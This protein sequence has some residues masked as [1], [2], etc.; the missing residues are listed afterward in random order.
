MLYKDL[1]HELIDKQIS[2]SCDENL[3]RE[4]MNELYIPI[5]NDV[6]HVDTLLYD[7]GA[8]LPGYALYVLLINDRCFGWTYATSSYI[9][10]DVMSKDIIN[11]LYLIQK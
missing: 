9:A 7:S 11:E 2:P 6:M 1:E 3:L 8:L 5:D 4:I 10:T